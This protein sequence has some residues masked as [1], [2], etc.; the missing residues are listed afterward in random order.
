MKNKNLYAGV[1]ASFVSGK[2]VKS[3][4]LSL[5][6]VAAIGYC[7]MHARLR[8]WP[9]SASMPCR[10]DRGTTHQVPG[11]GGEIRAAHERKRQEFISGDNLSQM[12]KLKRK[13]AR[14][15]KKHVPLVGGFLIGFSL[16]MASFSGVSS[17][18][19]GALP[20]RMAHPAAWRRQPPAACDSD[21]FAG[22]RVLV[23]RPFTR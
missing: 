9:S 2:V 16:A 14:F 21:P 10:H 23:S 17:V 3:L 22:V 8:F 1:A 20:G 6:P 4:A 15:A 18:G 5:V 13:L 12:G 11:S 19:R 7:V